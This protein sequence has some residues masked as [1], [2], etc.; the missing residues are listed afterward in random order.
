MNVDEERR[1]LLQE[2]QKYKSERADIEV[3]IACGTSMRAKVSGVG[4][5]PSVRPSKPLKQALGAADIQK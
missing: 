1:L 4:L 2:L 5:T 3:P